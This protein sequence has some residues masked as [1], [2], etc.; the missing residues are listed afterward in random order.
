MGTLP[1]LPDCA[2]P[3]TA[4]IELYTADS[5]DAC[6]YTC[7][8][9]TGHAT[10]VSARAGLDAHPIGLAP[11]VDRPCGYVHVFPTGTLAGPAPAACPRWCDRDDCRRRGRHRS[12]AR[13]TD[14]DRPEAFVVDVALAQALHPAAEPMVHLTGVADGAAGSVVLSIRQARVLRYRLAHLLDVARASRN[15]GRWA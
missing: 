1:T 14:T 10:T 9:H 5:L 3:A 15:A 8:A 4:R 6:A 2:E 13:Y 11:D 7:P 12:R